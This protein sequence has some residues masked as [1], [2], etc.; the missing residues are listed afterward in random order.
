V[1]SISEPPKLTLV[2]VD[3]ASDEALDNVSEAAAHSFVVEAN[4]VL[5]DQKDKA[6]SFVR[7]DSM[8]ELLST[9]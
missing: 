3:R 9:C 2:D 8:E 6:L 4:N 7:R 5:G 1:L